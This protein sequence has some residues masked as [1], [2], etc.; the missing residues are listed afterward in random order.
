MEFRTGDVL[1][2]RSTGFYDT[3]S[4]IFLQIK[5]L[6]CGLILMGEE[7]KGLSV[8][9]ESPSNTYMTFLIDRVFPIE[10]I[11]G[12]IW[13]SCNGCAIYHIKR[14]E[15]PD[16]NPKLAY[17]KFQH[18]LSMKKL[19]VF[20]TVYIAVAAYFRY[21]GIVPATGH[22][23]EKWQV[24]SIFIA[25]ILKELGILGEDAVTNNILP[26]DYYNLGFYQ[27]YK[28][29]RIT[30]FDKDTYNIDYWFNAFFNSMGWTV[31][32][33]IYN[34]KI[35]NMLGNYSYPRSDRRKHTSTQIFMT[36]T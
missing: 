10:E 7:F 29:E 6:H 22:D 12:H 2:W 18:L 28:Y 36:G 16:I 1:I 27:Q 20:H 32:E 11:I 31:P 24:C 30:L 21:G 15:G 13:T 34:L 4:D 23:D 9:G 19:S 33:P 3:L 35:E 26:I 14:I 8:C 25:Y 5:G 17:Q